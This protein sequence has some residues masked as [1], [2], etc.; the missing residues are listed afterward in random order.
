MLIAIIIFFILAG[1]FVLVFK[2]ADLKE[3]ANELE[4]ENAFLLATKIAN[5]PEFS[6]GQSFGT[7]S[8]SCVDADK[9]M[10]IKVNAEKYKEY[11]GRKVSNIEIKT[12]YPAS[13]EILCTISNYPNCNLISILENKISGTCESNFVSICKKKEVEGITINKCEIGKIYVCYEKF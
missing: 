4:G 1:L 2:L 8:V 6:C 9:A 10:I 13:E 5:S 7:S 3:S 12:I 11:W